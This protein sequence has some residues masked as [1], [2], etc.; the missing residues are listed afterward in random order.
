MLNGQATAKVMDALKQIGFTPDVVIGYVGWGETL[1]VKDIS[2]DKKLINYVEFCI[3]PK[4]ADVNFDLEFSNTLNDVLRIRTKNS[5]ILL[6]LQAFDAVISQAYW[7]KSL[8]PIEYQT[9]ISV[10]HKGIHADIAKNEYKAAFTLPNSQKISAKYNV[11]TYYRQ[12]L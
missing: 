12:K 11:V 3:T 1:Y 7:Q 5:I 8:Y 4:G 6:A 2:S 9:K 10:I